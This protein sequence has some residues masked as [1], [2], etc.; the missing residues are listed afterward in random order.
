MLHDHLL[1]GLRVCVRAE[2]LLTCFS[3]IH[4]LKFN[5]QHDH[6]LKR[7]IFGIGP[8]SDSGLQNKIMF[9]MFLCM[10]AIFLTLFCSSTGTKKILA[11][12]EKMSDTIAVGKC[13]VH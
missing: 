4:S 3:T 1:L 10:K 5:M 7:L 6:I 2:Y 8:T 9:D 11:H 12:C 13:E